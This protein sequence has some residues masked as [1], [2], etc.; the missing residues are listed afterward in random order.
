MAI[1]LL[2]LKSGEDVVAEVEENEELD[3]TS[4][5]RLNRY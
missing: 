2:R 3:L 1:K 5:Q 4:E